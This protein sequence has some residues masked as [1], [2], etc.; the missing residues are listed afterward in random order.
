MCN[1]ALGI[2]RKIVCNWGWDMRFSGKS[3]GD[4]EGA[5]VAQGRR[6]LAGGAGFRTGMSVSAAENCSLRGATLARR[7]QNFRACRMPSITDQFDRANGDDFNCKCVQNSAR[8]MLP[9]MHFIIHNQSL[10]TT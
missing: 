3:G 6:G 8:K 4:S 10:S 5:S 9:N 1:S 7:G 2:W